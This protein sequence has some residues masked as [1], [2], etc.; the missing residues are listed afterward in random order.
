MKRILM[1]LFAAWAVTLLG[2]WAQPRLA[3]ETETQWLGQISWK[4][5]VSV[6]YTVTNTGDAPLVLTEVEPDCSCTMAN[7]T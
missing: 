2:A 1:T 3:V 7:W 6:S 5:P 4:L